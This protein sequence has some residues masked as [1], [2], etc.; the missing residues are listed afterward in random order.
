MCSRTTA[1]SEGEPEVFSRAAPGGLS[2]GNFESCDVLISSELARNEAFVIARVI[3]RWIQPREW[4]LFGLAVEGV[5]L[6]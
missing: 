3:V 5:F 1:V 2:L 4:E 6:W